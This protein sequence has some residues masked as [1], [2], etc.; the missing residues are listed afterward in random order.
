MHCCYSVKISANQKSCFYICAETHVHWKQIYV[1]L[2]E[3]E[4]NNQS[5][6]LFYNKLHFLFNDNAI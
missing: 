6:N 4:D 2:V 5:T 1:E 3:K